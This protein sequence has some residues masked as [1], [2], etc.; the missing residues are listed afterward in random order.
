MS[1]T[2][3]PH[4][5]TCRCWDCV[6]HECEPGVCQCWCECGALLTAEDRALNAPDAVELT[7]GQGCKKC[8]DHAAGFAPAPTCISPGCEKLPTRGSYCLSHWLGECEWNGD[9]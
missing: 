5:T 9:L 6:N 4:S 3:L 8:L 1:Y 2:I 7:G